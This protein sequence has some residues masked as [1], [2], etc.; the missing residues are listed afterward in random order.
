MT[1]R[2]RTAVGKD[3]QG[4]PEPCVVRLGHEE[5]LLLA[6]G[7]VLGGVDEVLDAVGELVLEG[8]ERQPGV[9]AVALHPRLV[10][11]LAADPLVVRVV[12]A[13]ETGSLDEDRQKDQPAEEQHASM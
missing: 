10:G 7:G 1:L 12:R 3:V 4:G 6:A 2:S 11:H 9:G 13:T 5:A 8:E